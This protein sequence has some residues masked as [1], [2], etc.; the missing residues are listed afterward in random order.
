MRVLNYYFREVTSRIDPDPERQGVTLPAPHTATITALADMDFPE[1]LAT[2]RQNRKL[3]QPELADAI[4][5]HVSQLRRYEAGQS[6]P[7]L[8][9]LRRMA[10]SLAVSADLLLF[11]ET[12]RNPTD[13]LRFLFEIVAQLDDEDRAVIKAVVDGIA[14]RHQ[15]RRLANAS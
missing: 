14:L 8:D 1:R 6:Q 3:T 2:L 9:V 10:R 13:E 5:V 15:A 11:D 4:G 7:T 12:E